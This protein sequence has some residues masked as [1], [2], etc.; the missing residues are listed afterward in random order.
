[1]TAAQKRRSAVERPDDQAAQYYTDVTLNKSIAKSI[2]LVTTIALNNFTACRLA[3]RNSGP[4]PSSKHFIDIVVRPSSLPF[5]GDQSACAFTCGD[6]IE[7]SKSTKRSIEPL[8]PA[9][10]GRDGG[11]A[12]SPVKRLER[13]IDKPASLDAGI[14]LNLFGDSTFR[15]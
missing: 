7:T 4:R 8:A 11:S 15:R 13:Y 10:P 1:M 6:S 12:Y 5:P 3:P 14:S 9:L 2:Y